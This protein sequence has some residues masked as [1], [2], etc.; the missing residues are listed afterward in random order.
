[1]ATFISETDIKKLVFD[2]DNDDKLYSLQD[3]FDNI[4]TWDYSAP[5]IA[6][7]TQFKY[8]P[9]VLPANVQ[10]FEKRLSIFIRYPNIILAGNAVAAALLNIECTRHNY[11]IVGL[12]D[13]DHL[14]FLQEFHFHISELDR[15]KHH[16]GKKHWKWFNKEIKIYINTHSRSMYCAADEYTFGPNNVVYDGKNVYFTKRGFLAYTTGISLVE[17]PTYAENG[18]EYEPKLIN[19]YF[20]YGF[21]II[22]Y[23]DNSTDLSDDYN[24]YYMSNNMMI[25]VSK[26]IK[27]GHPEIYHILHGP[28]N[29]P[30]D[31]ELK[32]TLPPA[33]SE[34]EIRKFYDEP[35][36]AD[37]MILPTRDLDKQQAIYIMVMYL[38]NRSKNCWI[39]SK[40]G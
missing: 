34:D 2:D 30:T 31:L 8:N 23:D 13:N 20:N 40:E 24:I 26:P 27:C 10:E 33:I 21:E 39:Y 37:Y 28:C 29:Y 19:K 16:R 4:K 35:K 15:F 3:V 32:V 5:T 36:T 12:S 25:S 38:T 11:Y 9:A 1:M 18:T 7:K 6:H 17:I 14:S 22:C